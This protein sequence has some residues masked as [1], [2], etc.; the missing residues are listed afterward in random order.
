MKVAFKDHQ[1]YKEVES[2]ATCKPSKI[3][4]STSQIFICLTNNIGSYLKDNNTKVIL[5][6]KIYVR[7][8]RR[9]ERKINS[10]P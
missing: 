6:G 2:K 10:F 3:K 9:K 7:F 1:E 5:N 8:E 4:F